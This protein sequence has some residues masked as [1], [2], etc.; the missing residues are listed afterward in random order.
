MVERVSEPLTR[1]LFD[2]LQ[3]KREIDESFIAEVIEFVVNALSLNE[4]VRDYKINN[5]PWNGSDEILTAEYIY[6]NKRI[7]FNLQCALEFY[8]HNSKNLRLDSFEKIAIIYDRVIKSLLHEL[9]HANQCK[10]IIARDQSLEGIIISNSNMNTILAINSTYYEK[11]ILAGYS[12]KEIYLYF[13]EKER[14]Y[15]KYYKYDPS[16]RLAE[17]YSHKTMATILKELGTLP[18]IS[19]F[20]CL[21]LCQNYIKG[22]IDGVVP[23]KFYF[24]MLG[25][26]DFWPKILLQ[27]QNLDFETRVSLGLPIS[28]EE[29]KY[30]E[31]TTATLERLLIK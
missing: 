6:N 17:Y 18:N 14:R 27:S 13:A 8:K 1:F 21:K 12:E 5:K 11:L 16:E 29:Y 22:Y 28:K 25:L 9:E 30:L 15:N 2:S 24:K 4:Y 19:Y 20:E 10:K 3:T 23:T 31:S 26:S 7:K